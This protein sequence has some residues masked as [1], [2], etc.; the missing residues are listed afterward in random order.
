MAG[1]TDGAAHPALL[2][3]R[4][5]R[6]ALSFSGEPQAGGSGGGARWEEGGKGPDSVCVLGGE[7]RGGWACPVNGTRLA[8]SPSLDELVI[9]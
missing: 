5:R 9:P 8:Q 2:A 3:W 7:G 6:L 4:Q 1:T